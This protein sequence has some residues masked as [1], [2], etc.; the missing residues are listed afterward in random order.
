MGGG[1]ISRPAHL[2]LR[3]G[4]AS[5]C[6]CLASPAGRKA[7]QLKAQRADRTEM[8]STWPTLCP[9]TAAC[10][11]FVLANAAILNVC[12]DNDVQGECAWMEPT[13]VR[14]PVTYLK[15]APFECGK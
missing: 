15:T 3:V 1:I 14:K 7:L 11:C 5:L 4:R 6:I 9:A 12:L 2:L 10:A 13:G 8:G